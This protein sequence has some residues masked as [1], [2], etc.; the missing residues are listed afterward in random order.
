MKIIFDEEKA[1]HEKTEKD[2]EI[3]VKNKSQKVSNKIVIVVIVAIMIGA[4]FGIEHLWEN[5]TEGTLVE[6]GYFAAGVGACFAGM[7]FFTLSDEMGWFETIMEPHELYSANLNYYLMTRDKK[8][9]NSQLLLTESNGSFLG[10]SYTLTLTLED[11][12]HTVT[13]KKLYL[14]FF[15]TKTKTNISETIIVLNELVVY[16]PYSA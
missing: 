9:L 15:L 10:D 11:H 3:P 1:I 16:Q 6:M 7:A 4:F 12:E 5:A 8:V 14:P 13:E 2:T